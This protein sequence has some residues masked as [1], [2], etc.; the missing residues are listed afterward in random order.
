MSF[1]KSGLIALLSII[2]LSLNLYSQVK[3]KGP[4]TSKPVRINV[5][6]RE[7]ITD[8]NGLINKSDLQLR[9][10]NKLVNDSIMI[11]ANKFDLTKANGFYNFGVYLGEKLNIP[12]NKKIDLAFIDNDG[13]EETFILW[14]MNN[15]KFE[16]EKTQIYKR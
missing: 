10:L 11:W 7:L 3:E 12:V 4:L 9:Q 16:F 8:D 14:S 15:H 1:N 13:N 2:F 6:Y 5:V